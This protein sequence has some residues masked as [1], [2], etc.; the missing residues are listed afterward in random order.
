MKKLEIILAVAFWL[1]FGIWHANAAY[2]GML[3]PTGWP[4]AYASNWVLFASAGSLFVA[5]FVWRKWAFMAIALI[6]AL[7]PY[8][9]WRNYAFRPETDFEKWLAGFALDWLFI[10]AIFG[11]IFVVFEWRLAFKKVG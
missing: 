4:I 5:Y 2:V 10:F 6:G 3:W 7:G 8:L 1:A 9:L 11:L